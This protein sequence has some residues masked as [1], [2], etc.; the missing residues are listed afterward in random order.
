M[1]EA[2]FDEYIQTADGESHY[3]EWLYDEDPSLGKHSIIKAMEDGYLIEDFME[4]LGVNRE[5]I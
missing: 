5:Q 2:E 1:T 3:Y 4:H